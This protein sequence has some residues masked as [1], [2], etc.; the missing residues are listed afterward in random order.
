MEFPS[1]FL[2]FSRFEHSSFFGILTLG[3]PK[4]KKGMRLSLLRRFSSS[5]ASASPEAALI[6]A[7]AQKTPSAR[8]SR[9][10]DVAKVVEVRDGGAPGVAEVVLNRPKAQNAFSLRM[11]DELEVAFE[12]VSRRQD[13]IRC[14]ILRGEGKSFCS[15]IDLGVLMALRGLPEQKGCPA[16]G[17]EALMNVVERF[18]KI[19]QLPEQC[20]APVVALT[21]GHVI[22]AG[23][24]LISA[25]DLR[26]AGGSS[27]FCVKEIDLNIVADLGTL[28]R[29]PHHVGEQRARELAFTGRAF[30]ANEA[31]KIGFV[32][33]SLQDTEA[34]AKASEIAKTIAAKS[35]RTM[36]GIKRNLIF[37]RDHT[38]EEGLEHVLRW[39]GTHLISKEMDQFA[40]QITQNM[41]KP[42]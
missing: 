30:D 37:S 16:E 29:L 39:N 12:E 42:R 34:E 40:E 38:V 21:H 15:G 3:N 27:K 1:L 7:F 23:V 18:Q 28:Q 19:F 14:V 5:A 35:A 22:G 9:S 8:I 26:I 11:F 36:R 25:C 6:R 13:E 31:V 4:R 41:K 33:E 20:H 17:R 2:F 24:D 32:L 10:I